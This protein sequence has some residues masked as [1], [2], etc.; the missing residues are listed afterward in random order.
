[1]L[2]IATFPCPLNILV[3]FLKKKCYYS[4]YFLKALDI[5]KFIWETIQLNFNAYCL[6]WIFSRYSFLT[7]SIINEKFIIKRFCQRVG[8]DLSVFLSKPLPRSQQPT[9]FSGCESC[10]SE[11]IT[12]PKCHVI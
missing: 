2:N 11:K 9:N 1:M 12:F 3:S 5:L 6:T 7:T 8:D 10:E 4:N